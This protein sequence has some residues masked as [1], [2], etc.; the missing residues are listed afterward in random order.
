MDIGAAGTD[1]VIDPDD[2]GPAAASEE[3]TTS[4]GGRG[5]FAAAAATFAVP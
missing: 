4:V 3:T 1:S 2:T 5:C